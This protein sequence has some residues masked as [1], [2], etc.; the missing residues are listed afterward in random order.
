MT[1]NRCGS[2]LALA[3]VLLS[4][5]VTSS[6][7]EKLP[8][9]S[10]EPAAETSEEA[11]GPIAATFALNLSRMDFDSPGSFSLFSTTPVAGRST[12]RLLP[13]RERVIPGERRRASG[14]EG[15]SAALAWNAGDRTPDGLHFDFS[16]KTWDDL[17][18]WE[19]TGLVMSRAS[20]AA[21]IGYLLYQL[22]D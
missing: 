16:V 17:D 9:A 10:P 12:H 8:A 19:K 22:F 14:P 18:G 4:A 5:Q 6:G 2:V 15:L 20:A 3:V 11:A 21:G 1:A 13:S 7:D